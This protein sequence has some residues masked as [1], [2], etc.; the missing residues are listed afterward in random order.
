[1]K[2]VVRSFMIDLFLELEIILGTKAAYFGMYQLIG[3]LLDDVLK[4]SFSIPNHQMCVEAS[5]L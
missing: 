4:I 1:M 5:W 3:I 2:A